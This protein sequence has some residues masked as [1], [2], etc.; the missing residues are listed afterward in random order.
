MFLS[1]KINTAIRAYTTAEGLWSKAEKEAAIHLHAYADMGA[2]NEYQAFYDSLAVPLGDKVA[3]LELEKTDP[4]FELAR[5]GFEQ[6]KV[7]PDD[8]DDMIWLYQNFRH[9]S[10]IERSIGY[11]EQG[12]ELIGEMTALAKEIRQERAKAATD[13]VRLDSLAA[14]VQEASARLTFVEDAFSASLGE[15]ARWINRFNSIAALIAGAAFI[16]LT[17]FISALLSRRLRKGI[18]A[19]QT[20]AQRVAGGDYSSRVEART[21]D[22]LGRLAE[23][24]NRMTDQ[25][26]LSRNMLKDKEE[27]LRKY[28]RELERKNEELQKFARLASHDLQEPLRMVASYTQL[29]QQKYASQL[30][31]K[32]A[33]YVSF[34][35]EGATRMQEMIHD[36]LEYSR[37][38]TK[39]EPFI[40]TDLESVLQNSLA[41]LGPAMEKSGAEIT[42]GDM[43][44]IKAD[45][46]QMKTLFENL[47]SNA[48]KFRSQKKPLIQVRARRQERE[49][50]F[51]VKDNGIGFDPRYA[52]RVFDVFERLHRRGEYPGTGM[53]L[54]ICKKIVERHGG[55]IWVESETGKG[56]TFYFTIPESP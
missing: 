6:G 11:W 42:S 30:D 38:D 18:A 40:P 13:P 8:A 19:L 20:G 4:D 23:D 44:T 50:L 28:S 41:S 35:V 3:R 16:T 32:A 14:Q 34:A 55:Q 46:S 26:A 27:R 2:P 12:D 15:G 54:A 45:P 53:G 36:L 1:I 39:G 24:F 51:S 9:V 21:P 22:E 52:R 47:I 17:V 37:I 29:L 5:Q 43:P 25:L 33:E 56:S 31:A 49:W 48:I 10:Y 7:H